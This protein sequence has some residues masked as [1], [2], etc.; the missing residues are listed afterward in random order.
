MAAGTDILVNLLENAPTVDTLTA[1]RIVGDFTVH[2]R[3]TNTTVD[4]DSIIDVGVGVVAAPAF[5]AGQ[6]AIPDP[7]SE[8]SYPPRGWLYV[9]SM[10]ISETVTTSTGLQIKDA[11]FQFDIRSMRK[12]DKGVLFLRIANTNINTGGV[13]EVTGRIRA[14]CLT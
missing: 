4:S 2:Y 12:I 1:V 14:F 6:A 11:R 3:I 5:T 9:A 10:H 7:S 8:T 13:C